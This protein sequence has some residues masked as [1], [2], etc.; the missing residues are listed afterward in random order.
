MARCTIKGTG[1]P[2]IW[3]FVNVFLHDLNDQMPISGE[4]LG[5]IA[6]PHKLYLKSNLNKP[7]LYKRE[8]KNTTVKFEDNNTLST[9]GSMSVYT[10]FICGL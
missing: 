5:A 7:S 10:L 6:R 1:E 8:L 4:G 2:S 9:K 3:Y